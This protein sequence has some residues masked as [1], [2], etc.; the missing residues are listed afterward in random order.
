M[1]GSAALGISVPPRCRSAWGP[2]LQMP[3]AH[4]PSELPT[5]AKDAGRG[6]RRGSCHPMSCRLVQESP[7][8]LQGAEWQQLVTEGDLPAPWPAH[9][10]L[11]LPPD[12]K[13]W[14]WQAEGSVMRARWR[15]PASL[16]LSHQ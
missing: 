11:H 4:L 13:Y 7:S 3:A 10:P 15:A 9:K 14:L 2:Q 16:L 12:L 8:W 6:Q 5:A 1:R